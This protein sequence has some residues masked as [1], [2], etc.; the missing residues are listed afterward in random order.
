MCIGHYSDSNYIKFT[1][2]AYLTS[3]D[4]QNDNQFFHVDL[5]I[6]EP[7][8][9]PIGQVVTE[10]TTNTQCCGCCKDYGTTKISLACSNNFLRNGDS[11]AINGVIDHSAGKDNI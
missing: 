10:N 11:I 9:D 4:G 1:L 5:N 8:Q 6:I 3:A 7:M 2:K